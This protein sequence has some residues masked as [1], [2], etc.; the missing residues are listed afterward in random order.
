VRKEGENKAAGRGGVQQKSSV[1]AAVMTAV[2][3]A[4]MF[5]LPKCT[6]RS[7]EKVEGRLT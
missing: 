1:C 5:I 7:W 6:S 3:K 2:Y 4:Q